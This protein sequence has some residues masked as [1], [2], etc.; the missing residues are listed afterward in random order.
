M[1]SDVGG[2]IGGGSLFKQLNNGK[3]LISDMA[4][5]GITQIMQAVCLP[6]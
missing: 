2:E 1:N 3:K 6:K 4:Q 5:L